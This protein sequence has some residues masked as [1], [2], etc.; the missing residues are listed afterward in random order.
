MALD[1]LI[2]LS[3]KDYVLNGVLTLEKTGSILVAAIQNLN[4]EILELT[5][6]KRI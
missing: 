1:C 2:V 4:I 3:G 6:K 5:R